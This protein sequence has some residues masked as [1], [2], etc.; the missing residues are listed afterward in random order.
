[1]FGYQVAFCWRNTAIYAGLLIFG[2]LYGLARDRNITWLRWLRKPISLW[3][4]ILFL[5]PMAV[6]GFTH[7]FGLRDM[8]DNPNMDMWYGLRLINSGSQT[9]SFN[10]WLRIITGL[11]AALGAVWFAYPR[12]QKAMED[13]EALRRLYAS[14]GSAME[15]RQAS[16]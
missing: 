15:H 14:S 13:A 4:F 11:L 3:V 16:V 12:I 10:W 1:M 6:D 8:Y 5:L 7:M 2:L 9:F